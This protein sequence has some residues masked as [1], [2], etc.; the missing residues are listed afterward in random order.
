[1]IKSLYNFFN[2][3]FCTAIIA[4]L[5]CKNV[6][7][8]AVKCDKLCTTVVRKRVCV[9]FFY[10]QLKFGFSSSFLLTSKHQWSSDRAFAVR[11]FYDVPF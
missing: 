4:L 6:I 3:N 1:M 5:I 8:F 9:I 7:Y 10:L 11:F 2:L